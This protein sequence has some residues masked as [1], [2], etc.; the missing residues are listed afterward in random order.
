MR[1]KEQANYVSETN[2][3]V[4]IGLLDSEEGEFG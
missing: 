4:G 3:E 2:R 1:Q